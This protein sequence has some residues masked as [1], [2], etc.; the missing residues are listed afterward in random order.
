[1]SIGEGGKTII[2]AAMISADDPDNPP[3]SSLVFTVNSASEGQFEFS[4]SPGLAITSFTQE[5]INLGKLSFSHF[6]SEFSP[7]FSL[8]VSDGTSTINAAVPVINMISGNDAPVISSQQLS[9]SVTEEAIYVLGID[10]NT[11]IVISDPD[12]GS[13]ITGQVIFLDG[14]HCIA[15]PSVIGT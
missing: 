2:T 10:S 1:M 11:A 5:D 7:S 8:S 15:T 14:G 13:G 3:A 6:G 4:A 9:I 12:A